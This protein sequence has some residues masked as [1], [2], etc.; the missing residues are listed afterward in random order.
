M[1]EGEINRQTKLKAEIAR[2]PQAMAWLE[3]KHLFQNYKQ[4]QFFDTLALYFNRVHPDER[5]EQRFEHVPLNAGQD[6]SITIGPRGSGIYEISPYPSLL[7][8]PSLPSPAASSSRGRDTPAGRGAQRN[9]YSVGKLSSG[10]GMMAAFV[11]HLATRDAE[12]F[13][14]SRCYILT[15]VVRIRSIHPRRE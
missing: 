9:T 6:M 8:S 5:A 13:A 4:L 12:G 2:E 14:I 3:E 11:A 10:C 1:L 7:I 15:Y